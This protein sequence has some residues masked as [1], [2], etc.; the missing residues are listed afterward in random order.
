MKEKIWKILNYL[1]QVVLTALISAMIALLQNWLSTRGASV[2]IQL[3]TENTGV[4][5]AIVASGKIA[6]NN[7]KNSFC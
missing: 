4:I 7:I 6:L 5:G 1:S 2:D 3:N